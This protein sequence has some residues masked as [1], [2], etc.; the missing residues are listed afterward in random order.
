MKINKK[1]FVAGTIA[2]TL[3]MIGAL[4]VSTTGQAIVTLSNEVQIN[5]ATKLITEDDLTFSDDLKS[6]ATTK[7]MFYGTSKDFKGDAYSMSAYYAGSAFAN[8]K[9]SGYEMGYTTATVF[10]DEGISYERDFASIFANGITDTILTYGD[11][12]SVGFE[13]AWGESSVAGQYAVVV[14]NSTLGAEYENAVSITYAAE[15]AGFLAGI[16]AAAYTIGDSILN[17]IETPNIVMWGGKNYATVYS[18]MSGFAQAIEQVNAI[19]GDPEGGDI[20]ITLWSGGGYGDETINEGNTYG[21]TD[22][23]DASTW[24]TFGFDG[25]GTSES[26][27]LADQKT[28]NAVKND[29]SIIFPIAGGNIGV[30]IDYL[31]TLPDSHTKII[32]TDTDRTTDYVDNADLII[33][34]ATKNIIVGGFLGMAVLD[35]DLSTTYATDIAAWDASTKYEAKGTVLEATGVNG[36]VGFTYLNQ[37]G[38]DTISGMNADF[39]EALIAAGIATD[40]TTA[41]DDL[42]TLLDE[43]LGLAGE[44]EAADAAFTTVPKKEESSK[45]HTW[46]WITILIIAVLSIAGIIAMVVVNKIKTK[47]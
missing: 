33:G 27:K 26:A 17:D 18:F 29:A 11:K 32:G 39:V 36:G 15:G 35:E 20:N 46:L 6:G 7:E 10:D 4:S 43:Q 34:S 8:A 1:L 41:K 24:Y 3:L 2:S 30:A 12:T 5:N 16:A 37:E 28:I 45:S 13:N 40:A 44:I 42:Q 9:G 23:A 38:V 47:E 14:D 31:S 21:T 25:V 22:E 19:D